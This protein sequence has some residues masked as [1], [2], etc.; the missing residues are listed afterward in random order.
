M[1][2]GTA[3]FHK[4]GSSIICV[5]GKFLNSLISEFNRFY[6]ILAPALDFSKQMEGKIAAAANGQC[7]GTCWCSCCPAASRSYLETTER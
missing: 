3:W 1:L 2:H 4:R 6:T 7:P 5:N